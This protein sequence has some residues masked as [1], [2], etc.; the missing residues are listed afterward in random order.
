MEN[1]KLI[2]SKLNI[3]KLSVMMA[4]GIECFK[5]CRSIIEM[6]IIKKAPVPES[7]MKYCTMFS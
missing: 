7:H 6:F 1:A 3:H 5:K 4:D 2:E